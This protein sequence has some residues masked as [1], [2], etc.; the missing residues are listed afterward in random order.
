MIIKV[1]KILLY[2]LKN[3]VEMFFSRSQEAGFMEFIHKD[4]M[5]R[6]DFPEDIHDLMHAIRILKKLPV[7]EKGKKIKI[8]LSVII[9]RV[10]HLQGSLDELYA[11]RERLEDEYE[12]ILPFG[13]FSIQDIE[14]LKNEGKRFIQFFTIQTSRRKEAKLSEDLIYIGTHY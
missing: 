12:R 2:G 7:E 8:D 1:K 13:D 3:D 10:C 11:E 14:F 5:R 6:V 9:K 4:R